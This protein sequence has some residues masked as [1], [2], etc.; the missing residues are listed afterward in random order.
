MDNVTKIPRRHG[1]RSV[2]NLTQHLD[3]E[4]EQYQVCDNDS[5]ITYLV[6]PISLTQLRSRA[7]KGTRVSH[8]EH[9]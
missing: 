8:F 9:A 3:R 5:S 1:I 7:V 4:N 2:D 6:V